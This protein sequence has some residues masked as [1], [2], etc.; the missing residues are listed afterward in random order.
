MNAADAFEHWVNIITEEEERC[1]NIV[2]RNMEEVSSIFSP[3]TL[4]VPNILSFWAEFITSPTARLLRPSL[5]VESAININEHLFFDNN[6]IHDPSRYESVM[7]VHLRR[8]DFKEHCTNVAISNTSF[9]MWNGLFGLP[10]RLSTDISG[11][12]PLIPNK[13]NIPVSSSEVTSYLQGRCYPTIA[14]IVT[15]I[16]ATKSERRDDNLP[17]DGVSPSLDIVYLMTN[18]GT[19]QE[20]I[21]TLRRKLLSV[22]W[23]K[24]LTG[25]DFEMNPEQRAVGMAVDMEIARR[26]GVFIGNGWSAL[27]SGVTQRRLV[28]G[29]LPTSIRFW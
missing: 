24:V 13:E 11:Q 6:N 23:K 15:K 4:K 8:S 20:W 29:R 12:R 3:E 1:I 27:S 18:E 2:G 7:A 9:Y 25:K 10:D 14:S 26:A 19:E 5:L 28:N 17:S 22:G 16:N 21:E